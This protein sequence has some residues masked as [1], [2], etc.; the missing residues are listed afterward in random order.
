LCSLKEAYLSFK[1]QNPE[2]L[3]GFSKF[4]ELL[5]KN[6]VLAEASGIHAV[7]VCSN[8]QNVKLMISGM[9]SK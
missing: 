9:E 3:Q 6:S 2:K 5:P 7:C 8:H 1:Q 4:A